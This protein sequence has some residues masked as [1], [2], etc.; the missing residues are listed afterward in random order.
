MMEFKIV[1]SEMYKGRKIVIVK[2]KFDGKVKKIIPVLHKY[3]NGYV[4]FKRKGGKT[5]DYEEID[6]L[7]QELTYSGRL[8]HFPELKPHNKWYWGFDTAHHHNCLRPETRTKKAV[9]KATKELCD[10]MIEKGW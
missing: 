5:P 3:H 8:E 7:S 1:C 10:E 4:E 6:G 2:V 9:L